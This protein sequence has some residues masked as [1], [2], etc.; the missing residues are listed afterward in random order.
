MSEF[1]KRFLPETHGLASRHSE[2]GR[3]LAR[4][5]ST[6]LHCTFGSTANTSSLA[7]FAA[8]AEI[9]P[10][11]AVPGSRPFVHDRDGCNSWFKP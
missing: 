11:S 4:W 1:L 9:L 3:Q 5:V 7:V 10:C 6:N 2:M 8:T